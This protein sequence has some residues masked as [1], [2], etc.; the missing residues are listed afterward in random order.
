[1]LSVQ[2]R[3]LLELPWRLLGSQTRG[4]IEASIDRGCKVELLCDDRALHF[5][6]AIPTD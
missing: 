3:L 1:V 4:R 6:D 5:S 2:A